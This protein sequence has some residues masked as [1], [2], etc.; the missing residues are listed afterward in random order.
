MIQQ[1]TVGLNFGAGG[2]SPAAVKAGARAPFEKAGEYCLGARGARRRSPSAPSSSIAAKNHLMRRCA[3]C[4]I[5]SIIIIDSYPCALKS[6]KSSSLSARII[7]RAR[8]ERHFALP[9]RR[10]AEHGG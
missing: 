2:T 5:E 6:G 7:S 8:N 9:V 4:I 10:V 3:S 1:I